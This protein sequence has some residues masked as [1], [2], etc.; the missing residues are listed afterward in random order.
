LLTVGWHLLAKTPKE[1]NTA[2]G[3]T[4]A[5]DQWLSLPSV[6]AALGQN[7]FLGHHPF[8]TLGGKVLH[9]QAFIWTR[10][11]MALHPSSGSPPPL[12]SAGF[13]LCPAPRSTKWPVN[14]H[15]INYQLS[16]SSE[17]LWVLTHALGWRQ[18]GSRSSGVKPMALD[19]HLSLGI[20]Q[21]T[22]NTGG[23]EWT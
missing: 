14:S 8:L 7:L 15:T 13:S 4:L 18:S 20:G 10:Y 21:E 12:L 17:G 2:I 3:E 22:I 6:L 16:E 5:G 9:T 23:S 1:N 11:L 19:S